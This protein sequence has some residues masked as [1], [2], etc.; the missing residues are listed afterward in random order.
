[1]R[2]AVASVLQATLASTASGLEVSEEK[3]MSRLKVESRRFLVRQSREA[4]RIQTQVSGTFDMLHGTELIGAIEGFF[5]TQQRYSTTGEKDAES[6]L[7]GV[8]DMADG[9]AARFAAGKFR[10]TF[11]SLRPLL[12]DT[13]EPATGESEEQEEIEDI[14]P[15]PGLVLSK[16]QLDERGKFFSALLIE[17]WIRN[18]ANVRLLR[19]A[20]DIYPDR[21]FLEEVLKLCARD[22]SLANTG[23]RSARSGFTVWLAFSGWG[24]RDRAR[25][26]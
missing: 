16:A 5:H 13:I 19:I 4:A 21:E 2:H 9:T 3:Q 7:V 11:R 20:L 24:N 15:R 23:K 8:P 25:P 17:D 6:L 18:P 12:A 26:I 14:N 1:M 10:R 22:G